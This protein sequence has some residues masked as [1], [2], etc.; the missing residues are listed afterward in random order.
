MPYL[1]KVGAAFKSILKNPLAFVRHLIDAGILGLENFV[2]NFGE[3]LKKALLDWL[4]GSLPGVYIPKAFTL[5][6]FGKFVLSVLGITWAQI[7]AK[8][9][10]ALGPNG[11][12]IM[13]GLETG[14]EIVKALITGG[15]AAAW[16]L[17]KEKLTNLK[18]M[19]V[20]GIVGFVTDTIIKKAIPKL[21]SLFIPGA[22]F[23]SAII[24]IYDSI[25][26]FV[27]K[28]AKIAAA[29][30]AFV[31]SIVAIANGQIAGAAAKVE[32]GLE[33]LLSITISFLAGFLGL[34]G[35]ASKVMEVIKK[36]QAMVD[37]GLDT[38]ITWI[39][40]KA[41]SF[42]GAVKSTAQNVVEALVDWWKQKQPFQ[43]AD[44]ASHTLLFKGDNE[45]APLVFE[46]TPTLLGAYLDSLKNLKPDE[47]K[48]VA[49]IKADVANINTIRTF[50][51]KNPTPDERNQIKKNREA[52]AAGLSNI[53][54]NLGK[55]V[56]GDNWGTEAKPLP[57]SY[58]K[59]AA[60]NYTTLYIGPRTTTPIKQADT[61][62]CRI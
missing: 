2:K 36:L 12:T 15:P 8:I 22:G 56:G 9:V 35:I 20:D 47:Q 38:A 30:K 34:G 42:F 48:L 27:Q 11:E 18:D 29:V 37:K 45:D 49:E 32:S 10:K 3:H 59:P 41:K 51:K 24:S 16:D 50:K 43:D 55:L 57:L 39:V 14:F 4:T 25:M 60:A 21:I 33:S 52:V 5:A 44:G 28:L 19:V 31:D 1:R 61:Y 40:T 7:R 53:S 13:K 23:I 26:V 46:T 6:E 54:K 62:G 17:I 58:P